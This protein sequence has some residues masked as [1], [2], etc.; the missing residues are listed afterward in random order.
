[1]T[2]CQLQKAVAKQQALINAAA[3]QL[4]KHPHLKS[5]LLSNPLNGKDEEDDDDDVDDDDDDNDDEDEDV[6]LQA[7]HDA[8][9]STARS[10]SCASL[11]AL[12]SV[13]CMPSI[14]CKFCQ[15]GIACLGH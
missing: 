10:L 14:H 4:A 1:M 8:F 3:A 11:L 15:L 6:S 12:C 13:C 9:L 7:R 5:T 2:A